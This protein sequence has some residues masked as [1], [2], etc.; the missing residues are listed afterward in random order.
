MHLQI[1]VGS[2]REGRMARPVA[3]WAEQS[4][5][6]RDGLSLELI[7]LKDWN[8]PMFDLAKPPAMGNYEDD[9]QQRWAKKV[10]EADAYLIVAPEYNHGY[11]AVL[12]NAFDYVYAEWHRKPATFI[13][14]GSVAG[15]RVVEQLRGVLVELHIAPLREALH[16]KDVWGK[17]DDGKFK[18][19]KDD[20]KQL[21][22][23]ADE[24]LWWGNALKKAREAD[25]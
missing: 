10:A 23:I 20:S 1:I 18:D 11:S 25:S 8:L 22:K 9:L 14:Y 24:L 2:I 12:K 5:S 15:G 4:L 16:I 6:G 3:D 7:D 17:V 13:S 21:N 19:N